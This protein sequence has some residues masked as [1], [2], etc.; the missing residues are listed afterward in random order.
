M[1]KLGVTFS[2]EVLLYLRLNL[3]KK[4]EKGNASQNSH[5]LL[6]TSRN[7]ALIGDK[8]L[9]KVMQVRSILHAVSVSQQTGVH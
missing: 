7:G 6:L 4:T 2:A 9:M 8:G 1:R 3:L 5:C